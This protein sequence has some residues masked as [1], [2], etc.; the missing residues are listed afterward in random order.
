VLKNYRKTTITTS[1]IVGAL[2]VL[3]ACTKSA[4]TQEESATT[5]AVPVSTTSPITDA[6]TT[7]MAASTSQSDESFTVTSSAMVDGGTLPVQFTCDGASQ[8]PPIAWSGAPAGTKSFAVLMDHQPGPGDWHW[9]WTLWGIKSSTS[10]IAAGT[11]GDATVGTNSVNRE[12]A[13]TPPCSKGPGAKAYT[14]T[15]FA[16]SATPKIS[17]ANTVDRT[18]LLAAVEG[19]TLAKSS[20]TVTYTR[21]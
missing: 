7:S 8:S 1:L 14:I 20:I 18:A 2:L 9:Y 21:S 4:S 17:D 10:S 15:V 6:T 12:L 11:T 5:D 13:Y 16:L 19:I 3:T